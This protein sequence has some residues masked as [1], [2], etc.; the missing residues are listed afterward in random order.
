MSTEAQLKSVQS[1][2][3]W[4]DGHV[5][6]EA[7]PYTNYPVPAAP[8]NISGFRGFTGTLTSFLAPDNSEGISNLGS[9]NGTC[10]AGQDCGAQADTC[11][12]KVVSSTYIPRLGIEKYLAECSL[13]LLGKR[14]M[15]TIEAPCPCNTSYVSHACCDTRDGWVWE[16]E[17][18][19]LGE[20]LEADDV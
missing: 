11:I 16:S 10:T 13:P 17:D 9:C 2:E 14:D 8:V 4:R 18:R 19:K 12:C 15:E 3:D 1:V 20:L 7:T 5:S 6:S